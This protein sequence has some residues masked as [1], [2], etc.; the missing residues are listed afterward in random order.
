MLSGAKHL[1]IKLFAPLRMTHLLNNTCHVERSETSGTSSFATLRMT[2]LL[3]ITCH[4]ERSETSVY[5]VLRSAQ[6][7]TPTQERLSC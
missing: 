2:H 3:R 1:C 7:D 6:D 4:V 5:Q